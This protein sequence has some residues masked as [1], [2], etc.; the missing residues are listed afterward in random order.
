K[1]TG[2]S[3][4]A[5]TAQRRA[6]YGFDGSKLLIEAASR[7][8]S[9]FLEA[10]DRMDTKVDLHVHSKYSDRPSECILR[11]VGAPES[12][13]E[14]IDVYRRAKQRGMQFVP[15]SDHNCIDGALEIAHLPGTFLSTEVTTYFPEDGCKIHCLV[16]GISER[17]FEAIEELRENI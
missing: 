3:P 5:N 14:P 4:R 11:R 8:H 16:S 7:P 6:W 10:R 2:F 13:V 17:Q 1:L 9:S 12:F 15:I